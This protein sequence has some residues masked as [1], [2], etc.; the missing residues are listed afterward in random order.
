MTIFL[1]AAR[2]WERLGY[3]LFL[4][5]GVN[6]FAG[7][8]W[9]DGT[10][11]AKQ[12]APDRLNP[13][14]WAEFAVEGGMKYAVLTAKH[15]DGFC[16][17][18]SAHTGYSV[19]N[20]GV[21]TDVVRAFADAFRTAGLKVGLYYSLWDRNCPCYHDDDA[22]AAYMKAQLTELL[23]GYGDILELWFDGGWDKDSPNRSWRWEPGPG[24]A[25]PDGRRW[26]WREIYDHI[27]ALQP[28]CMVIQN[29]SSNRPG[30]IRYRPADIRTSEHFNFVMGDRLHCVE[31]VSPDSEL[32]LEFCTT[33]TPDWFYNEN[34]QFSHP[35]AECIAGWRAAANRSGGNLLLNLGPDKHGLLPQYHYSFLTEADRIFRN[36]TDSI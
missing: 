10:F 23:T 1:P 5:F 29:S 19:A 2:A 30:R 21:R 31:A 8:G 4:H 26:H 3:G 7:C 20:A 12:F 15:H 9:G 16:L 22:Y 6:T 34:A 18:P 35:S 27:H 36:G 13:C 33:L 24:D 32:P 14:Q 11:P 25:A 17:W 28:E